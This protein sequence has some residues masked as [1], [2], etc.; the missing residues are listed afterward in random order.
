MMVEG[1]WC[2]FFSARSAGRS[3]DARHTMAGPLG[4]ARAW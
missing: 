4:A 3:Y 2:L 1:A